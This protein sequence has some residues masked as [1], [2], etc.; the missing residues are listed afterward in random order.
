MTIEL[1]PAY[2]A[3]VAASG[4]F[5]GIVATAKG[6]H[7]II[8]WGADE[9]AS[10]NRELEVE[11]YA[12]GFVAFAGNGGGEVFA[13]DKDGAVFMLPTI[14]MEP[15]AAIQVASDF[16]TLAKGFKREAALGE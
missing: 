16:L 1:P 9:V 5:E 10:G 11:L 13:F 7:D 3:Y 8:L 12:P 2:R 14:G 15:D 4:L 6:D